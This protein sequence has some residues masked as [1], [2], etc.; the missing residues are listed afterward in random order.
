M[1]YQATEQIQPAPRNETMSDEG[2]EDEQF[3]S[4]DDLLWI[5]DLYRDEDVAFHMYFFSHWGTS[6]YGIEDVDFVTL[7]GNSSDVMART[8]ALYDIY[9]NCPL[10]GYGGRLVS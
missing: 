7:K 9:G 6:A 5:L 8:R 2:E 4:L 1:N 10:L 3:S